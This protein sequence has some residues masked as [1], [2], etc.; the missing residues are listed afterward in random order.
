M[1]ICRELRV[2]PL[3][4]TCLL[5]AS[6]HSTCAESLEGVRGIATHTNEG[7]GYSRSLTSG[8]TPGPLV[9]CCP[10]WARLQGKK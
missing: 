8:E 1:V 3:L 6:A 7:Y 5:S 4:K 2:H 9:P 10:L